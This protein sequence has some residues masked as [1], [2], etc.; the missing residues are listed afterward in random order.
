M[1]VRKPFKRLTALLLLCLLAVPGCA[2]EES[3]DVRLLCL[4]IGKADCMLL[5]WQDQVYLI[6]T[7]LEQTWPALETALSQY[8]V[9]HLNGVIL[10]HCHK[11]HAGGML[12]LSESDIQVDAWYAS[13][14]Y[15]STEAEAH[16]AVLA[17]AN[18]GQ[19]VTWLNAGDVIDCTGGA[20]F[21]ALGPLSLDPENENNNSLVLRFSSPAGSILLAGDM[22]TEEEED[23][24]AAGKLT[25]CD[26]LKC[27]HHGDNNATGEDLLSVV[28]PKAALILT[29]TPEEPDTPA[30]STVKRLIRAGCK[31]YV[32]QEYSDAFLLTLSNGNIDVQDVKWTGVPEA[33]KGLSLSIDL[34][35]D[36]VTIRNESKSAVTLKD[37]LLFS[38]RGGEICALPEI[39]LPAGASYVIGSNTTKIQ[40]DYVWNDK[41]IWH[42]SKRDMAI[43]YDAYGRPL[44]CTDNGLEE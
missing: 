36:A 21:T 24:L 23:L 39:T 10:T 16:P 26:V 4:N 6:D 9:E 3:E 32:S 41:K 35:N 2:A 19:S 34:A 38:S 15:F 43:L 11:D 31:I 1:N 20:S 42:K 7:G 30:A 27:G 14:V 13:P 44:A 25:A 17:A 8:G 22:K 5:F 29:S 18:R 37:C 28:R 40:T 33:V 12:A